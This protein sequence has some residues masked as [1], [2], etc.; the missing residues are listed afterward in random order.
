MVCVVKTPIWQSE[1]AFTVNFDGRAILLLYSK[2]LKL[3]VG[4]K[5][6][7][8]VL[9]LVLTPIDPYKTTINLF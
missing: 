8:N 9:N 1:R 7:K 4:T 2:K 6:K 5:V 3:E